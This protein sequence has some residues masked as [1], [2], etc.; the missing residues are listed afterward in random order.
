MLDKIATNNNRPIRYV[1]HCGY[2]LEAVEDTKIDFISFSDKYS[3]PIST[4]PKCQIERPARILDDG[5]IISIVSGEFKKQ[6]TDSGQEITNS[7][8]GTPDILEISHKSLSP[9]CP[10]CNQ[11]LLQENRK[12]DAKAPE[13]GWS[14][15]DCP[16]CSDN[17]HPDNVIIEDRFNHLY[18]V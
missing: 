12:N 6:N 11:L 8:E 2:T 14:Y 1:C 13:T 3:E 10:N 16:N 17:I 4:C 18:D 15:Y 7:F 9:E 5:R